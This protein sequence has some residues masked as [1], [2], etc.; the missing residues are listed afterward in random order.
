MRKVSVFMFDK[1]K[2]KDMIIALLILLA[3]LAVIVPNISAFKDDYRERAL[4]AANEK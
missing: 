3:L 2:I 4:K 1:F